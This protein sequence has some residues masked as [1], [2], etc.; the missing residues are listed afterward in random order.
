EQ[1]AARDQHAAY[2]LRA[3]AARE[4]DLIGAR[5][6]EA[7]SEIER[8]SENVR[9]AWEWAVIHAQAALIASAAGCLSLFYEWQGRIEDG[10]A[11]FRLAADSAHA[12]ADPL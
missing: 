10:A 6:V 12:T 11:A 8:D 9:A 3:L 2:Y 7:L 1:Q 4:R 5:Q